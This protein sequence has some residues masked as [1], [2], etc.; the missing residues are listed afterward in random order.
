MKDELNPLSVQG[1]PFVVAAIV[2]ASCL[3][4]ASILFQCRRPS[5][6]GAH[7]AFEDHQPLQ[8]FHGYHIGYNPA[9]AEGAIKAI[10]ADLN[11]AKKANR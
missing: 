4:A 2:I 7:H 8:M 6:K 5:W 10:I 1:V 3:A 11:E 9:A